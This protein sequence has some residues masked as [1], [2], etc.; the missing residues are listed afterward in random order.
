MGLATTAILSVGSGLGAGTAQADPYGHVG[1]DC[2]NGRT[3][4][5]WCPGEALPPGN[6]VIKWDWSV[7]HDY[8]YDAKG[9][10]DAGNGALYAWPPQPPTP[11]IPPLSPDVTCPPAARISIL[12]CL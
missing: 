6:L 10:V 8:Y 12:P 5:Q 7:C 3:C 2:P 9:V 11:P 4:G 1:G